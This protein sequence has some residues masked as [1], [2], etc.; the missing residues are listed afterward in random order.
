MPE[1]PA[2]VVSYPKK[3]MNTSVD[4]SDQELEVLE[5]IY[6]QRDHVRQR[7]LARIAG[8][9]LGMTNAIVKRLVQK[10]WLTIRKVNNRNIRYA[11]SADGID[12]I[13]RRSYRY[14]KRT[15]RNIVY[16]R[17]AIERFVREV[18][19]QGYS[20]IVLVGPSDLDFIVEHACEM[21][22]VSYLRNDREAT[23]RA[24]VQRVT[25]EPASGADRPA[26]GDGR[27]LVGSGPAGSGSMISAGPAGGNGAA[28]KSRIFLLYSES[29]IPD[30]EEKERGANVAFLQDVVSGESE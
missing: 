24:T 28:G 3:G 7:D 14:L 6:A 21:Y 27:G 4:A 2:P 12:Q 13:T 23:E 30:A 22:A 16:Y 5:N 20:G 15:I 10:G 29:Y 8:L 1:V 9:S 26:E 11:V 17:E 19:V 25:P 18:K